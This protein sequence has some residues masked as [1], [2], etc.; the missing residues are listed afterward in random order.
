MKARPISMPLKPGCSGCSV[1]SA[2]RRRDDDV[3]STAMMA[4]WTNCGLP[5]R[6]STVLT[7]RVSPTGSGMTRLRNTSGPS[8]G[9]VYG[10]G[11]V[12][13]R[14]GSPSAQPSAAAGSSGSS[15]ASPSAV[16]DSAHAARVAICDSVSRRSP[17][18]SPWPGSGSQGGMKRLAVTSAICRARRATSS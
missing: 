9:R 8:A 3:S 6:N 13:V 18:N 1:S 10:A 4:W 12:T 5:G 7:Q 16:P 11:S 17:T 14:S 15:A 2:S